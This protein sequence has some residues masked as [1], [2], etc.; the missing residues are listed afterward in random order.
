MA[1]ST[2]KSQFAAGALVDGLSFDIQNVLEGAFVE[3]D[4]AGEDF[5]PARRE[6][7]MLDNGVAQVLFRF[8]TGEVLCVTVEQLK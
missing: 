3:T 6:R 7:K 1:K 8:R 4:G 5:F 2:Q